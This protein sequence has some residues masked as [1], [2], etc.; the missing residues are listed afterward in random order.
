MGSCGVSASWTLTRV[1]ERVYIIWY[2]LR[3]DM[4]FWEDK[5]TYAPLCCGLLF[6]A[7]ANA[8]PWGGGLFLT[9][10][11]IRSV[12]LAWYSY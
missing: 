9:E 6:F 2:C 1:G 11:L 10:D 12:E 4:F 7:L 8:A 5:V 3:T